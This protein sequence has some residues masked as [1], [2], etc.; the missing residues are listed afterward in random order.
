MSSS[1]A[2]WLLWVFVAGLVLFMQWPML[3]GW[4]YRSRPA[5]PPPPS[6]E[7][8][9]DLDAALADARA[10]GRLVFVDFQAAWCPPCITMQHDVWPDPA[11]GEALARGF[12]PVAIDVDRDPHTSGRYKVRAIPTLLVL[13]A[14]GAV[15]DRVS[16]LGTSG[17]LRLLDEHRPARPSGP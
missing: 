13:D 16:Y 17:L 2:S 6:F 1:R 5:P 10:S 9:T 11:V 7:W 8:R 12:V 15:L 14:D 3:K 4:Y